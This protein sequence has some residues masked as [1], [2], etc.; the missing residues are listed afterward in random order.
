M[1]E[2][3]LGL[4]KLGLSL[5]V[6]NF[7]GTVNCHCTEGNYACIKSSHLVEDH[8]NEGIGHMGCT[9]SIGG[10]RDGW[11]WGNRRNREDGFLRA[12]TGMLERG[13]ST[14]T[15]VPEISVEKAS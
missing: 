1:V 11:D 3:L 15:H 7:D 4:V 14:T 2:R 5:S 8:P 6:A 10:I 13:D 9:G 12:A